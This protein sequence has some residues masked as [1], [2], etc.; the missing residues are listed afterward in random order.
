MQTATSQALVLIFRKMPL[1]DRK[2][3]YEW[4][5]VHEKE[6]ESD[7]IDYDLEEERNDFL[8]LSASGLNR[9]YSDDEPEYSIEDCV[10]IN[11]NFKL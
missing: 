9:A 11:P 4:I 5:K 10:E 1:P 3:F 6:I 2:A 8:N 7:T